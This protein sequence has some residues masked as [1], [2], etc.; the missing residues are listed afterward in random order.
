MVQV[1]LAEPG[2]DIFAQGNQKEIKSQDTASA[3]VAEEDLKEVSVVSAEPSAVVGS[4][5]EKTREAGE[6][7][8]EPVKEPDSQTAKTMEG[9][10]DKQEVEEAHRK[11][12]EGPLDHE[13]AIA[14]Q[15]A[16]EL[17]P[18]ARDET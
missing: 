17:Y 8:G 6:V 4:G 13:E 1:G 9:E 12:P 5:E 14:D 16:H 3:L 7:V 11:Q 2:R 15:V 10:K 18:E